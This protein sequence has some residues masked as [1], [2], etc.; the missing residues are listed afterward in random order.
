MYPTLMDRLGSTGVVHTLYQLRD[1]LQAASMNEWVPILNDA[2]PWIKVRMLYRLK[3]KYDAVLTQ[4]FPGCGHEHYFDHICH[5]FTDV[6]KLDTTFL[7]LC[8]HLEWMASEAQFDRHRRESFR[9][10][11]VREFTK[12]TY[13]LEPLKRRQKPEEALLAYV[14]L[15]PFIEWQ[16]RM[17]KPSPRLSGGEVPQSLMK[18]QLRKLIYASPK[19]VKEDAY[20]WLEMNAMRFPGKLL[21][22]LS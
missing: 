18:H 7:S 8:Y 22:F 14:A 19:V 21:S 3:D 9:R 12:R 5:S 1:K 10:A 13:H 6:N 20:L 11:F 4:Y 16:R 15:N 17:M 2:H